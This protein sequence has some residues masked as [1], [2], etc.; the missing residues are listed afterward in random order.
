VIRHA[1]AGQSGT[2]DAERPLADE[3][4][5]D[6]ESA[7]AWL[8]AQ[9]DLRPDHALVSAATRAAQTWDALARGAGWE[10]A[11]DLSRALYTAEPETALD[12]LREVPEE[13]VTVAVVGH[14]PTMGSMAQLLDD[15]DG[16]LD[17]AN[18]L[19]ASGFPAGAV[20]VFE[21]DGAWGDLAWACARLVGYRAP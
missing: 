15:G 3:G 8:A 13:V 16:D 9:D 7:G 10:L 5:R 11:T 12:L 14:N 21:L 18:D 4:L 2:T 17:A 6:A 19:V 1:R 20:A